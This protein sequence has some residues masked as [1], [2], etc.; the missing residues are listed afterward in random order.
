MYQ[1]S[2]CIIQNVISPL[3]LLSFDQILAI[4]LKIGLSVFS[5]VLPLVLSPNLSSTMQPE[6][7]FLFIMWII[8]LL[9]LIYASRAHGIL[10]MKCMVHRHL[11]DQVPL[12]Y[13][14]PLILCVLS[15]PC[16]L[17]TFEVLHMLFSLPWRLCTVGLLSF[18]ASS[19][20]SFNSQF[21][22]C[23]L[24][25]AFSDSIIWGRPL[26][27]MHPYNMYA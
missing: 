16:Q 22:Y 3:L 24:Q 20:S 8:L 25:K 18:L 10:L 1:V 12:S 9:C 26:Y 23:F 5:L 19:S 13:H 7:L 6:I 2:T 15:V 4:S 21:R 11:D 14:I 27:Y 17:G